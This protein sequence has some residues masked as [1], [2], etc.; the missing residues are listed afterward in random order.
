MDGE[1]V[2][3]GIFPILLP[4]LEPSFQFLKANPGKGSPAFSEKIT[5]GESERDFQRSVCE[6]RISWFVAMNLRITKF[7]LFLIGENP[8]TQNDDFVLD[9]TFV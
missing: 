1:R 9:D 7:L 6:F 2:I 4:R 8:C 5:E 3:A